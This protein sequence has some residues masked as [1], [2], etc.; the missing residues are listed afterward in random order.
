MTGVKRRPRI[1][2]VDCVPELGD[3]LRK[4]GFSCS[5]GTLG[6]VVKVPNEKYGD[7]VECL[8]NY[9]WPDNL[10]EYDVV[11]VDLLNKRTRSYSAEEH[12]RGEA[13]RGRQAV[14]LSHF[15][16]TAFDSRPAAAH[17]LGNLLSE[18]NFAREFVLVVFAGPED[19]IEYRRVIKSVSGYGEP[20]VNTCDIHEVIPEAPRSSSLYGMDVKLA[21]GYDGL[22]VVIRKFDGCYRYYSL[23]EF[24]AKWSYDEKKYLRREGFFPLLVAHEDLIASYFQFFKKGGVLVLPAC[25][26]QVKLIVDLLEEAL[27]ELFPLVFPEN[28]KFGWLSDPLY[29]V[30]GESTLLDR[31][32]EIES[33]YRDAV[34]EID[35]KIE[36]NREE[37]S[38]LRQILTESGDEL[39]SSVARYLEWLGFQEVRIPDKMAFDGAIKEEDI[40]VDFS[41]GLLV[42]EVKG[43]SGTST[44]ADCSQVSKIKYR[45]ARERGRFDVFGLY[46]VNHER[47]KPP[48][49]R[50]NPPFTKE[51]IDDAHGDER[52]L[53]TTYRLFQLYF[54]VEDGLITKADARNALRAFGLV[55]F[56]PSAAD[57][58]GT[59]DELHYGNQV[60][61]FRVSA[62]SLGIGDS[63]IIQSGESLLKSTVVG[64]QVEGEDVKL[65]TSGVVGVKVD[66]EIPKGAQIWKKIK[67][68][69]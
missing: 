30:P 55:S 51:Q 31:R 49:S 68:N 52:G 47:F 34:A 69:A 38:F 15:P 14:F 48:G 37:Y 7:Y 2:L 8:A 20:E 25:T 11:I 4:Q 19:S 33:K 65:V 28:S 12:R 16:D 56:A 24:P 42:I 35:A 45:R 21:G 44:D 17:L 27:P 10:H 60:A 5:E 13:K 36:A 18:R 67:P 23:F 62:F 66:R 6:D 3:S 59:P 61:I 1:C 40:Q 54:H 39:V 43:L 46:I 41:D 22:S 50:R 53:L 63:L 58:L 64:L 57:L 32:V 26:E 9:S 29:R